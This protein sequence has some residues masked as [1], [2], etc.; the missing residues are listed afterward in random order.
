[1]IAKALETRSTQSNY[2]KLLSK[3]LDNW[4]LPSSVTKEKEYYYLFSQNRIQFSFYI[5]KITDVNSCL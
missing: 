1:M 3:K 2:C 4:M 5:A